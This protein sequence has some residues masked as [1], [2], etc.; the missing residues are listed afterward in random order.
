MK[1]MILAAG[2]GERLRP[3]TDTVPKPLLEVGGE[4]LILRHLRALAAAGV[5]EAVVNVSWLGGQIRQAL[6]DRCAGVSLRWSVEP[7]V[8]L[9]TGGGILRALE[10][11]GEAPF[12]LL[13]ADVL[14]DYGLGRLAARGL[15]ADDLCHLVLVPNPPHH[16]EGDFALAGERLAEAGPR[17]TYSGMALIDP[18]LFAGCT[19][20]RFPLA[21]LLRQAIAAGRAG[22]ECYAGYWND[23]GTAERLAAAR[24]RFGGA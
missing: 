15:V 18:R 24:T 11:L 14:T 9:E 21:P 1:A 23:V 19:P 6:G 13:N 7:E 5:D 12:L 20:G 16:A 2:R 22:G 4:S 10:V 17:L 8:P 3:L